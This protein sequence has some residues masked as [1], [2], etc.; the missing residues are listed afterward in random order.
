MISTTG[1]VQ[2]PHADAY[3][4]RLCKHFS[5]KIAI[6]YGENT[7]SAHFPFGYCRLIAQAQQTLLFCCEAEDLARLEQMQTV[8]EQHVGM[9]S[10]QN[11]LVV[12]WCEVKYD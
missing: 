9:F 1:T 3:L 6:E 8:I 5:K 2:T 4:I 11:P 10:R 12:S 7:A